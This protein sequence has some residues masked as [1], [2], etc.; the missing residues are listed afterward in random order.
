MHIWD[1]TTYEKDKIELEEDSDHSNY[2]GVEE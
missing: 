1:F 2:L